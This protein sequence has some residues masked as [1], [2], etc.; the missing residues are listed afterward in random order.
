MKALILFS[1]HIHLDISVTAHRAS[2][3]NPGEILSLLFCCQI[4]YWVHSTFLGDGTEMSRMGCTAVHHRGTRRWVWTFWATVAWM[5]DYLCAC[6]RG[7]NLRQTGK[8]FSKG[9]RLSSALPNR[10]DY[11]QSQWWIIHGIQIL[12][13]SSCKILEKSCPPCT[14]ALLTVVINWKSSCYILSINVHFKSPWKTVSDFVRSVSPVKSACVNHDSQASLTLFE[15]ST[16]AKLIGPVEALRL[17]GVNT[18]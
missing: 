10:R 2:S 17:S 3:F 7:P 15:V 1:F 8:R 9:Q 12:S 13:L 6:V 14:A 18:S 4:F 11:N 16:T 5:S